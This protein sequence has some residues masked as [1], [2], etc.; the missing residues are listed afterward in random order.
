MMQINKT[1]LYLFF[2]LAAIGVYFLTH[3][4]TLCYDDFGY[5]L[6]LSPEG[7]SNQRVAGFSDLI[8]SQYNHYFIHNGRV[9]IHFIV[10]LFLIPDNKIWFDIS[11]A[12]VFFIFQIFF[13][14]LAYR[15]LSSGAIFSY[16]VFSFVAP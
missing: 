11:N 13:F 6:I 3:N 1:L 7:F 4:T 16:R 8:Y 10:Q 5:K 9:F 12:I 14:K 15:S 2:L